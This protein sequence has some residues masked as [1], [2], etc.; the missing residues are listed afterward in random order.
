MPRFPP[1]LSLR[2]P[3]LALLCCLGLAA[4]RFSPGAKADVALPDL[5]AAALQWLGERVFHNECSGEPRCL[6]AWNNGEDF[7][8][9]GLGHFIWYRA[10]QQEAF[11]ETFPDLLRYLTQQGVTLPAW[12]EQHDRRQPWPDRDSFMAAMDSAELVALRRLLQETMPEQARFILMRFE[13]GLTALLATLDA[14]ERSA[15]Q[16]RLQAILAADP[17]RGSY[18]LI[19]YVHF[20]GDGSNP[21]ERYAGE[22]WGLLQVLQAMPVHSTTPLADFVAAGKQVLS[23]RVANAPAARNEQRWLQGWHNRLDSYLTTE[24]SA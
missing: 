19:D 3:A 16:S 21:R 5:D 1:A 13:A 8:S 24:P 4:A 12:I 17:Q 9:L 23:R 10:G 22:G 7:P 2:L 6:T 15:V 20:K 11:V 18:A 14:D